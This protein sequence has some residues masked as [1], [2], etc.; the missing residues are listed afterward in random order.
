M[1]LAAHWRLL[2]LV[3]FTA[4]PVCLLSFDL[5]SAS[6]YGEPVISEALELQQ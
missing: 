4:F 6:I 2:S 3:R 1:C 5:F